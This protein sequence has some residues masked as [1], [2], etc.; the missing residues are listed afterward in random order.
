M[1][2]FVRAGAVYAVF[3][4][5]VSQGFTSLTGLS[6]WT[7]TP[8]GPSSRFA[9]LLALNVIVWVGWSLLATVVFALGRRV[10]IARDGWRRALPFHAVAS[11]VVTTAHLVMGAT[12]RYALQTAWGLD[13]L[14]WSTVTETFLR[15]PRSGSAR[16]SGAP[17]VPAR[18]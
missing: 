12:G 17:R 13:P 14:W 10:N 9:K 1:V 6:R 7:L 5:L 3:A 15:S 2:G 8:G 18:R 16:V 11:V 4:A